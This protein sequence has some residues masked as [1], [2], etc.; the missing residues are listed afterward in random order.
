MALIQQAHL[1]T[2]VA[3]L[4]ELVDENSPDEFIT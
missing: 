2:S 1:A 4:L 3:E